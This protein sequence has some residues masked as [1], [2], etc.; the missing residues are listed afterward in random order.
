MKEID[1]KTQEIVIKELE[2][3]GE[4][5]AAEYLGEWNGYDVFLPTISN[6]DMPVAFIGFAPILL[7]KYHKLTVVMYGIDDRYDTILNSFESRK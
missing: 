7:V 5:D 2:K 6:D 4:Y 3:I 1:V